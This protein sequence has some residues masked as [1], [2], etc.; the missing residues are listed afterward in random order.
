M[1]LPCCYQCWL[2]RL[3][4]CERVL[5]AHTEFVVDLRRSGPPL[6]SNSASARAQIAFLDGERQSRKCMASMTHISVL[7][8]RARLS[9]FQENIAGLSSCSKK[10]YPNGDRVLH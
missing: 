7:R 9:P 3:G 8:P 2:A 6:S 5:P 10:Q 4:R 1:K